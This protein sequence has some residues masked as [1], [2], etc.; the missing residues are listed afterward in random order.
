[1]RRWGSR[2][3]IGL[4]ACALLLPS[5]RGEP[6]VLQ[7]NNE[8]ESM[9]T[10]APFRHDL[11]KWIVAGRL[12]N[13]PVID[14]RPEEADWQRAAVVGG[15]VTAFYEYEAAH[16]A[17]YRVAYD[18]KFL[19]I[20]G[21]LARPAADTLAQIELVIRPAAEEQKY[22]T[23]KLPLATA[24]SP[25]INTIWN[26]VMDNINVSTDP[27]RERVQPHEYETSTA[28]NTLYVE[29]S[30]PLAAIAAG[31]VA[32]GDEWRFNVVHV[33][34]L[35]TQPLDSW[36][37][38]RNTDHWHVGGA[39]ANM[40]GDLIGQDRLGSLF[41]TR[42][43]EK[44]ADDPN[45][46][47]WWR[48]AVSEL[49]YTG[50]GEKQLT[51]S[52]PSPAI[53]VQ[54][55]ALRWR[56]PSGEW[57]PLAVRSFAN[58]GLSATIQF[59][60]PAM[61]K[62]GLYQ[63]VV[64]MAPPGDAPS[65]LALF[66]LDRERVIEGGAASYAFSDGSS[67]VREVSPAPVSDN[68][69]RVLSL[70]PEQPGFIF[71]G[72][73]EMPELYPQSLY[74]LSTDGLTM[75]APRT[76]TKYPNERFPEDKSLVVSN[77]LGQSVAIPY[78]ED[79]GGRK[80]FISAHL[81]YLQKARAI[82]QTL[83]IAKADPLGGARLLHRFAEAY[84]GYNPTV[85]RV[86]GA[87]HISHSQDRR[88]GPPYAYW[89]GVWVRWWYSDLSGMTPLLNAFL[90]VK[91]TNA[92]EVLSAELGVD[93]ERN[94]IDNMIRPSTEFTLSYLNRFSNM[95]LSPWIGLISVGKTLNDPDLIHR[96]VEYLQQFTTR[97]YL[98]DGFWQEVTPSYHT[99]TVNGLKSA[100]AL[101]NG[102][103]DP[104]GYVSPRSGIRFDNLDL[105]EQFPVIGRAIDAANRL[106]YPDGRVLPIMDTWAAEVAAQPAPDGSMLMPGA[107]I[108]R[109]A[110]GTGQ[111]QTHVY[112]SFQP[113]YGHT[114]MDPLNLGLY[115]GRQELLPDIGYSHNTKYRAFTL[116]TMGH[117]TVVVDSKNM[118]GGEQSRHGGDVES[119][120]T[121]AG[122]FQAMR[123]S[124]EGA[125]PGVEE[126]SREPWF[127]PFADGSGEQGYVLD[128][129]RV[130]GGS[131][132]EY[133]LQGDANRNA[134]FRTELPLADYG[135]YLLPPGTKVVEPASNSDFGSAEGH[136][137]GYIYV[138]D[139]KRAQLS[140]DR[141]TVSLHTEHDGDERMK[142]N[143]TG[144]IPPGTNELYLGRSPSLRSLR[145]IGRSMDNNDEAD[146]YDMPKLVLRR[147]GTNL[148]S[149]FTT[150][151][152]PYGGIAPRIEAIDRL[153]PEQAPAGAVAVKVAYGDTIDMM[154]SNPH[155]PEQPIVVGDIE[156]R[157]RM[158][159]IRLTNGE[160]SEMSLV[161]GTLLK[162]GS[163]VLTGDGIVSGT[164]T[165]TL[166]K[167]DGHAYDAL[168]TNAAVPRDAIGSYVIVTHPDRSTAGFRIGDVTTDNGQTVIVLAEHDPGFAIGEG[169]K[170]EYLFYPA[171]Q[172][173]TGSHTFR[174]QTAE[175]ASSMGGAAPPQAQGR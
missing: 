52:L 36:V 74:Q 47:E 110:G 158:G 149:T 99:Q 128:L 138:R 17:E 54:D 95:S 12:D 174:I 89:G 115:A 18:D 162:K 156:M 141:F 28:S 106:V 124:Y 29:A 148:T 42:V 75:T 51:V 67:P 79:A 122:P 20:S 107:K 104:V 96:V 175:R 113:K 101:L 125:Y 145:V 144:L 127:I 154:F 155:H 4:L 24:Q 5:I 91:K 173:T 38:I 81:W 27:G 58:K 59:E 33:H 61:R 98:S 63:L 166:R 114:H 137:P 132:H 2:L 22:Y 7:A 76:G 55:V 82:T 71:A 60:H 161:G 57:Q 6:E 157:G 126:Y 130:S 111:E 93:V 1:M 168:V 172:W 123:A 84:K 43:S 152:E 136:Y 65:R 44:L 140:G 78:H 21:S 48:P 68:V 69:Q 92:F 3:W 73:P 50:F 133:T 153:E 64:Q 88:S 159:F 117:N 30:V 34:N 147:D 23:V 10:P 13:A 11:R 35:Y 120:V 77:A 116:S 171:K 70:I 164:I 109:L 14:G 150:V 15:F 151:L 165:G 112:M 167:A 46:S 160:V 163:H 131:R 16:E 87:N 83:P 119:F 86:G 72:L 40:N 90:E 103:S 142:L 31:G 45:A 85:D 62:D 80:Y 139:V 53:T 94:V 105:A 118:V 66:T 129:F 49:L 37:P 32:A 19:Y 135:P 9:F 134:F 102:W 108:G 8:N 121:D 169:G 143:I 39:T 97:M 56:E 146:K 26:P 41:F 25:A 100:V 170:S